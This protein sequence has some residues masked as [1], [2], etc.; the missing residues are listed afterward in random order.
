MR[1]SF[2]TAVALSAALPFTG[3]ATI[4]VVDYSA[5]AQAVTGYLKQVQ[6]YAQQ[7]QAYQLQ[8]QQYANEIKQATGLA[9]AAQI[10]Q[11][12]QQTMGQLQGLCGQFTN[13]GSLQ[14]YL[15]Q[16]QNVNY[17]AQVPPG[18][19]A[20][21]ANQ[22]WDQNSQT[23]KQLNDT[24]AQ[25]LAQHQQLLTQ[26]AAALQRAQTNA[27]TAQGQMQAIQAGAQIN[28]AVAQQLL[29]IHALLV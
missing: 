25:S 2:L 4:P 28:A 14:N 29:E 27:N 21:A 11:Q 23:Q 13:G 12:Y 7:V 18:N 5:I 20:Q 3:S 24:W 9:Q 19:Y 22:S 26:D 17:C 16:F 10:Y 6:Q 15:Q 1:R 8:L